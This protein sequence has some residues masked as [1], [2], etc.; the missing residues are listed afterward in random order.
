MIYFIKHKARVSRP[1]NFGDVDITGF[2][3]M[4][5]Q[6]ELEDNHQDPKKML[7]IEFK[8]WA[9]TMEEVE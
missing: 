1:C 5:H 2:S 4:K 3:K 6:R 8:D 7:K 9:N